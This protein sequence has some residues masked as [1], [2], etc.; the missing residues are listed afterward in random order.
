MRA[1]VYVQHLLGI[2]HLARSRRIA[3]SLVEA[4]VQTMLVEGGT[5]TGLAPAAGAE[6]IQLTPVRVAA[7]AM[8]TLLHGD[9]RPF[10]DADR[11][12]R[13]D[14]LLSIAAR[15]RPDIILIEAFP[16]GRRAMRFEL[17]PL[18]ATAEQQGAAVVACSIRDILQEGGDPRRAEETVETLNR[19]FN[20]LL[21]HGDEAMTPLSLTFPMADRIR[22]PIRYTGT[23][24]P[25]PQAMVDHGYAV[26]VSAGGGI[27]GEK[28]L[29]TAVAARRSSPL[30]DAPWLVLTG[31]NLPEEAFIQLRAAA[32]AAG[33]GVSVERSVRDLASWLA[34]AKVSISQAGYN[35][36][37]D[38]LASGC[39][40]V[41]CPFASGGETEQ[42]VRAGA[43][44]ARRRASV[45]G[46]D[47]L[48]PRA[49]AD[50]VAAALELP[51]AEPIRHDGG[52]RS[53]RILVDAA[54]ERGA[55]GHRESA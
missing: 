26:I 49:L 14:Q 27:V 43:L 10:S 16:F 34:S 11:A 33:P 53:A 32:A 13:R 42:T 1:L 39:A 2:G 5:A 46:E 19:R 22:I 31:P 29:E 55:A 7:D 24:G 41:L 15:L 25:Q 9:G 50:A 23:V 48:S 20:M 36:V 35:T 8:S 17:L 51:R 30:A 44:A 52:A 37:S 4:G 3:A 6:T 40:A 18:I 12:A 38:I 28:L 45:L 21:V 47:D 54:L